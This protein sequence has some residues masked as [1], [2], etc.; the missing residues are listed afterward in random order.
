MHGMTAP[1]IL[2]RR[3]RWFA[4]IPTAARNTAC[5]IVPTAILMGNRI[6]YRQIGLTHKAAYPPLTETNGQ[7]GAIAIGRNFFVGNLQPLHH[8]HQ[9]V[10]ANLNPID[11]SIRNPQIAQ[12][13]LKRLMLP[14]IQRFF[15]GNLGAVAGHIDR[16]IRHR[17][18]GISG[19]GN[20]SAHAHATATNPHQP[21]SHQGNQQK[22]SYGV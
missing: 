20:A 12:K 8:P 17:E 4:V 3:R 15:F 14:L 1:V 5:A 7:L 21:N 19:I 9:I 11:R 2:A 10:I 13:L 18:T 6:A 16:H 22:C